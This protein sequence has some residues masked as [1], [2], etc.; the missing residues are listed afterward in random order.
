MRGNLEAAIRVV[1]ASGRSL[2]EFSEPERAAVGASIELNYSC[3]AAVEYF[4][5]LP[6]PAYS[7]VISQN[8]FDSV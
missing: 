3:A 2:R 7:A 4:P 8:R 6:S 5:S 1:A